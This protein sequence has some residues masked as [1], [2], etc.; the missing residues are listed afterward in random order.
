VVAVHNGVTGHC[1]GTTPPIAFNLYFRC[2]STTLNLLKFCMRERALVFFDALLEPPQ[3]LYLLTSRFPTSLVKH[4]QTISLVCFDAKVGIK[5]QT[6]YVDQAPVVLPCV[7]LATSS[8][9]VLMANSTA[10]TPL[11]TKHAALTST[12]TKISERNV[13]NYL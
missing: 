13:F 6:N 4:P 5:L 9:Q 11:S 3:R 7:E 8:A 10:M 12:R 1:R 2:F